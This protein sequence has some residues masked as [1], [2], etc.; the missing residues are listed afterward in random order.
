MKPNKQHGIS[1]LLFIS[2]IKTIAIIILILG[3]FLSFLYLL[4]PV[5]F[6]KLCVLSI[7]TTILVSS[8]IFL[9]F[10]LFVAGPLI[11]K[12]LKSESL[13]NK[14]SSELRKVYNTIEKSNVVIVEWAL[15][16]NLSTHFIS[17]NISKYGYSH[18]DFVNGKLNLSEI[19][20]PEDLNSVIMQTELNYLTANKSEHCQVYRVFCRDKS[21]RWIEEYAFFD[22]DESGKIKKAH[23]I[24]TDITEKKLVEERIKWLTYHD[25]LTGLYNRTWLEQR[26]EELDMNANNEVT[27][28]VG[29]MNGLKLVN[30]IFGHKSGDELL[31]KMAEILS[32]TAQTYGYEVARM[33]GDEFIVIMENADEADAKN[34]HSEIS[35]K[36]KRKSKNYINP[37][38]CFGYCSRKFGDFKLMDVIL[39]E[40][41]LH[42]Y[43]KKS[44]DSKKAKNS[45]LKT[46]ELMKK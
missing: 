17:E 4:S 41:D 5:L 28:M 44:T 31:K 35:Q 1:K 9:I 29:D 15:D 36:C 38:I 37:S 23:G 11:S 34:F 45:L 13:A 10:V 30:D 8:S 22:R 26:L 42:M 3:S 14:V 39:K 27:I 19:L 20:H 25:K 12:I 2:L 40:A 33:G 18:M 21:L 46:I 7:V 6:N 16:S 43:S 32:K 24:L